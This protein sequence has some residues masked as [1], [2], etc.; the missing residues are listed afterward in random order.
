[1]SAVDP[2]VLHQPF[3]HPYVHHLGVSA[4]ATPSTI[5]AVWDVD[6]LVALGVEIVHVH[7]GFEHLSSAGM[8]AWLEHL[9]AAGITLVHT[10]H[11]LDNPHV[12][13]QRP[14]HRLVAQLV[15]ASAV[16]L[17][18]TPTAARAIRSRYGRDAVV[19]PH[20]HVVPFD[21]LVRRAERPPS[22]RHGVYVHAATVRPNLDA[23][24][25]GRLA[26]A[27]RSV[28]GMHV[29]VR[30]GT[31]SSASHH[32]TRTATASGATVH[33]GRR[34]S[35][36]ELW[37]RL[38]SV[39]LVVLPYRWGTHSGLLEAAHDLGTPTLAPAFGG[40]RD[41][42]AFVLDDDDLAGSMR[43]AI[44]AASLLSVADRQ[45]RQQAIAATHGQVYRDLVRIVA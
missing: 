6:E 12:I 21:E 10:V 26:R 42:G 38:A 39:E 4:G 36:S 45:R 25:L 19:V 1:M 37:R 11:D 35:D 9:R 40:Y 13:D 43:Q 18:L 3:D 7:F 44:D 23:T 33:V 30:N 34:L 22:R 31:P 27:A 32:L 28:G 29:H 41:Q 5:T 16:V 8:R 24:L 14:Y 20:P 2:V 15:D 17:T